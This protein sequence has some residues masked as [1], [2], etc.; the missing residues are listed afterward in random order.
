MV[1]SLYPRRAGV[2]FGKAQGRRASS[3]T[4]GPPVAKPLKRPSQARAKFTV[5]VI[6][7]AFVRIWHRQG[8]AGITTRAV[9]LE[10]G[11][12]VGALY[13]YFPNKQALLSGYV[14]H[15]IDALLQAIERDVVLA[16]DLPWPER[17]HRLVQLSCGVGT[18]QL[19]AFDA[20]MLALEANIAEP[21][22]H[23]RVFEELSCSWLRA[24]RACAD[25]PV[26]PDAATVQALYTCIWGARRY[27]L[28]VSP[29]GDPAAG[30]PAAGAPADTDWVRELQ[31]I[32]RAT[33]AGRRSE[34]RLAP[35]DAIKPKV[36]AIAPQ[37]RHP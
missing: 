32:C 25:L 37:C 31:H 23:R 8:W 36:P 28:L 27:L 1:S 22:H 12:S 13:D 11:V 18:P 19:P 6:Y 7:D 5:Q 30:D 35:P 20:E 14:R 34:P 33:L 29:D 10:A 9:A 2:G 24:I 4:P 26:Q 21:K 3:S 17:V 15:G 16:N